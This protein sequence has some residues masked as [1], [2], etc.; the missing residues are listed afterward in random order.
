MTPICAFLAPA[1]PTGENATPNEQES[2]APPFGLSTT[3]LQLLV[4]I[5]NWAGFVPPFDKELIVCAVWV[6][7][8]MVTVVGLLWVPT[9]TLPKLG[10][11][12]ENVP[13]V[14]ATAP[15]TNANAPR[16]VVA[17]TKRVRIRL[18]APPR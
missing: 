6:W 4:A 7:F 15:G 2:F 10:S 9:A 18:S 16:A 12:A 14:V 3:P 11:F 1:E 5:E 13:P 17:M 8:T